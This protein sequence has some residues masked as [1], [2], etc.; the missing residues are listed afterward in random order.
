MGHGLLRL[1]WLREELGEALLL[2]C[3]VF[4]DGSEV[5]EGYK[6]MGLCLEEENEVVDKGLAEGFWDLAVDELSG[7]DFGFEVEED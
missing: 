6:V 4:K 2:V 5:F 7:I 1:D 3:V